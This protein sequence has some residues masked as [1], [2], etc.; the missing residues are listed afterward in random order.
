MSRD[1]NLPGTRKIR[2][3]SGTIY[4]SIDSGEEKPLLN[5]VKSFSLD[6]NHPETP[7]A[8]MDDLDADEEIAAI[9]IAFT[10]AD[11]GTEFK[12]RIHPRVFIEKPT[13]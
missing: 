8:N 7:L 2:Y 12:L 9:Y 4:F 3:D 5:G 11:V 6:W 1:P 13:G 10:I